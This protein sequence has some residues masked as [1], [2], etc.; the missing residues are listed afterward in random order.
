MT[1]LS[2]GYITKVCFWV[3]RARMLRLWWALSD[4]LLDS[5]SSVL[6]PQ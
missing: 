1:R 4:Y 2:V 6:S 3:L 5:A